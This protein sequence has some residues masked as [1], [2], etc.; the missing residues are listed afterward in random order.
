MKKYYVKKRILARAKKRVRLL[1]IRTPP[2]ESVCVR[3]GVR[4]LFLV[5]L[6]TCDRCRAFADHCELRWWHA[7]HHSAGTGHLYQDH[8][9]SFIIQRDEYLLTVCCY[10]ERNAVR[11]DL[12]ER[13]V[14]WRW[15]SLWRRQF[16]DSR[17]QSF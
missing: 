1:E 16:G 13:A 17:A 8:F 6:L 11:A 14:N 10:V 3:K 9:K 15:T 12:V 4:N 5:F 7:H 2:F